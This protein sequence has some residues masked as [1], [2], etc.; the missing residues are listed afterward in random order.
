MGNAA[1]SSFLASKVALKA[2]RAGD[3]RGVST[4]A[5][6]VLRSRPRMLDLLF[7]AGVAG[8]PGF[9]LHAAWKR[10]LVSSEPAA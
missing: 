9:V 2:R 8:L 7:L 5:R 4:I 3:W 10:S 1:Y 6:A